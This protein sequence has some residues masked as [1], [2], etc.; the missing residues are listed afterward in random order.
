MLLLLA[1]S[2]LYAA[3]PPADPDV[4]WAGRVEAA[5]VRLRTASDQL[6]Q[7]AHGIAAAGR[8]QQLAVLHADVDDVRARADQLALWAKQAPSL[9][10]EP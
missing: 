6:A 7:T 4:A 1:L 8:V 10:Q 2:T 3:D 9:A 5:A